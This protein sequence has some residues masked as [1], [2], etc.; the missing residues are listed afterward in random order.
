MT[1]IVTTMFATIDVLEKAI[2]VGANFIIVYDPTFYNHADETDWLKV[3]RYFSI[4]TIY[5]SSI[6]LPSGDSMIIGIR[7]GQMASKP[8]CYVHWPGR[9]M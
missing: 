4:N 7:P 3:I 5:S 9:S 1:G 8:A 6:T 2:A